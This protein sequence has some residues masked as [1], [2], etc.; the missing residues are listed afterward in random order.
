[1]A[2][3][4]RILPQ[5]S[6]FL[7]QNQTVATALQGRLRVR[8]LL[9]MANDEELRQFTEV[10]TML[11]EQEDGITWRFESSGQYTATSSY[12]VQFIGAYPDHNRNKIWKLKVEPKCRFFIWLLLQWKLPTADCIKK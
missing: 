11:P 1:M 6:A 8:S 12:N 2:V 3:Q 7:V 10:W 5:L 4:L 9:H